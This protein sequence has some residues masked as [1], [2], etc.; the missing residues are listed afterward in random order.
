MYYS[1]LSAGH[2]HLRPSILDVQVCNVFVANVL[3][4]LYVCTQQSILD[5]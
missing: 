2:I 5:Y 3:A 4:F 1:S